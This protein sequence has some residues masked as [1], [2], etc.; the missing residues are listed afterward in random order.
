MG[1]LVAPYKDLT[2][3]KL[4][5]PTISKEFYNLNRESI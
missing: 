1:P 4:F 3:S 5:Y 2:N